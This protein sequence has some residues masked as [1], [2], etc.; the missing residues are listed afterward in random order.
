[1]DMSLNQT[2]T[3]PS[4]ILNMELFKKGFYVSPFELD[5]KVLATKG[6]Y[7]IRLKKSAVLPRRY[8]MIFK[9]RGNR[10]IY[11]G[12][13]QRQALGKRLDQELKH[14]S[15]GTFFRS[16]GAVLGYEPIPGSLRNAKNKKNYKFSKSD[17]MKI[18]EWLN[19][20]VEVFVVS[21]VGNF[22]IES[23]I[24]AKYLPLL[25]LVGNPQKC[26]ELIEDRKRCRM[27]ANG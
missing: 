2:T 22:S 13:A 8:Q 21:Y 25:N 18:T 20:S 24:I 26:I 1:M 10:I 12:K 19:E 23:R 27:I 9:G 7:S 5:S 3:K 11:M 14:T 15:P 16:I 17:T 6:F 4:K